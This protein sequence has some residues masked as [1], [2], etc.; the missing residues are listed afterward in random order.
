MLLDSVMFCYII[1]DSVYTVGLNKRQKQY[2]LNFACARKRVHLL[3]SEDAHERWITIDSRGAD[4][5]AFPGFS[6]AT[7][8]LT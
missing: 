3:G 2:N 6:H 8:K 5:V 4:L 7:S 1:M